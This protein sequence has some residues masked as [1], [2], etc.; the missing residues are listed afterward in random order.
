M[1][2]ESIL[3]RFL[4]SRRA[5]IACAVL[6][7]VL[8]LWAALAE[9]AD[10]RFCGPPARDANGRIVRREAVQREFERLY[11]RPRDGRRWY[12]D[13]PIPLACGGCDSIINMQWLP[14]EQWREKSRW[15][16]KVYGGR[17]I[18]KGCP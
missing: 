10:P 8:L 4:G 12:K 3:W 15:E 16:R 9:A 13:H 7:V 17:G 11:P 2:T 1:H 6:A 5:L 18:S 14:E